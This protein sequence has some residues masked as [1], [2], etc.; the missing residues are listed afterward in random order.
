MAENVG[1]G[2]NIVMYGDHSLSK[3]ANLSK[4]ANEVLFRFG[5]HSG[6]GF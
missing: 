5:I 4:Q 6:K 2:L 1:N 3:A